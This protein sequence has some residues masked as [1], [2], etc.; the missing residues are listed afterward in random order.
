MLWVWRAPEAKA[1]FAKLGDDPLARAVA[2]LESRAR[3][4]SLRAPVVKKGKEVVVSYDFTSKNQALLGDFLGTGTAL[5]EHGMAWTTTDSIKGGSG[6]ETTL[7]MLCWKESLSPPL[8]IT[9]QLWLR[10]LTQLALIGVMGGDQRIRAG[11]KNDK[12]MAHAVA[13]LV[14][15]ENGNCKAE[16]GTLRS[17]S[18]KT[19]EPV[20]VEITV[21]ADY[22]VGIK[23]DDNLLLEGAQLPIGKPVTLIIQALQT[24]GQTTIELGNLKITGTIPER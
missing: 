22:Q 13:A 19:T 21:D 23:Y 3:I 12:P 2:G 17:A 10:P 5:S 6:P 9:C 11:F 20:R 16:E 1:A 4:L 14:T 8:T 7:P 24:K 18:F 15:D